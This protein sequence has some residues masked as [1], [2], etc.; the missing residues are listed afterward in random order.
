[1]GNWFRNGC[2]FIPSKW[3]ERADGESD[4]RAKETKERKKVR[5]KG[6]ERKKERKLRKQRKKGN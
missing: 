5:K 2:S 1:V 6:M 4:D 3:R